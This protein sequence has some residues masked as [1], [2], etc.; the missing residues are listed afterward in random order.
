MN[1]WYLENSHTGQIDFLTEKMELIKVISQFLVYSAPTSDPG[2][3][4]QYLTFH[5]LFLPTASLFLIY[6]SH[7]S[8]KNRNLKINPL[9]LCINA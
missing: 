6:F 3:N 1:L 4:S 7:F 5:N 9:S 8:R 2:I